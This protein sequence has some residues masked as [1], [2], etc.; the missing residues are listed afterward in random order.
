MPIRCDKC[1]EEYTE[2]SGNFYNC[3]NRV[4]GHDST[5]IRCR[6]KRARAREAKKRDA[7]RATANGTEKT[8]IPEI[9]EKRC[10]RCYAVRDPEEFIYKKNK[11]GY[12]RKC[13]NSYRT[14][15]ARAKAMGL[16]YLWRFGD[17]YKDWAHQ[18]YC[19]LCPHVKAC[20]EQVADPYYEL[21]CVAG[22]GEGTAF[23]F[24]NRE[25]VF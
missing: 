11:S 23:E 8:E 17:E 7:K 13:I 10:K 9:P 2:V 5:C 25:K 15:L 20:M 3:H 18:N 6:R 12:C 14:R 1:G 4:S 22:K 24:D 16:A 19:M 21:P